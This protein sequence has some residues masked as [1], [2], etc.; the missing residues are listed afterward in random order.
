MLSRQCYVESDKMNISE[1]HDWLHYT[2]S[3]QPMANE[4]RVLPCNSRNELII[5]NVIH[6]GLG[7]L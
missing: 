3:D 5:A 2:K 6:G 7:I 4:K 1:N